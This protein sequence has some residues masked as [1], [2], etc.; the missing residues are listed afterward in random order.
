MDK[1]ELLQHVL[2]YFIFTTSFV[3]IGAIF[4]KKQYYR[5]VHISDF[6]IF[7]L[8][9]LG[10]FTYATFL[11]GLFGWINKR[12]ILVLLGI[13]VLISVIKSSKLF[14]VLFERIKDVFKEVLANPVCM[15]AITPSI[16]IIV[17]LGL[18][19]LTP[20]HVWDELAYHM[21]QVKEI[22]TSQ[23][24]SLDFGGHYFYG[25]IP[26]FMELA[27]S[28]SASVLDYSF[29]H[30]IHLS[31]FISFIIFIFDYIKRKYGIISS[32]VT[33]L[34]L[35]ISHEITSNAI[36]GYVDTATLTFEI[37]SLILVLDKGYN[38]TLNFKLFISGLLMGLAIGSK[39]SP[40]PTLLFI[41]VYIGITN[42]K[43]ENPK[44]LLKVSGVL[45]FVYGLIIF[46]SFWYFKNIV[47]YLNPFY[48]F[49]LGHKGISE[50]LYSSMIQ[51]VQQFGDRNLCNLFKILFTNYSGQDFHILPA[52]LS[53]LVVVFIIKKYKD[54]WP[55]VVYY[56]Y[57]L[58]YWFF[59]GTHQTRFLGP[60]IVVSLIVF[61]FVYSKINRYLTSTIILF[62][63]IISTRMN[64][65]WKGYIDKKL[66]L[67]ERRYSLG[68]V[69]KEGFLSQKL[70]C[71]YR[72]ISYINHNN[73]DSGIL[74]NWSVGKSP[75]LGFYMNNSTFV[76]YSDVITSDMHLTTDY[77]LDRNV[78][79]LYFNEKYR[80]KL[81][82]TTKIE[83][84]IISRSQLLFH[85]D[86]CYLYK[87][88][89]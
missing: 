78:N 76:N 68:Q 62:T 36:S 20:P 24:I 39:Y 32:S 54:I 17:A 23:K 87:I 26:K 6:A 11:L 8:L 14:S 21:P 74:D 70:G 37:I 75:P 67:E 41:F 57:Y 73:I 89:R 48:P 56:F 50:E 16:V 51:N 31:V 66:Y 1:I 5:Q 85:D 46:G 9:G 63:L 12:N 64:F 19:S 72:T 59:F 38:I 61:G 15:L 83:D 47:L 40:L 25:N 28:W 84:K 13:F 27:Y 18:S 79:Y 82:N 35:V 4:Y 86:T 33:L 3:S 71:Q 30:M 80:D 7:H 2:T 22:V 81:S 55:L 69:S 58:V 65:D 10:L 34:L 42:F 43:L 49:Y 52:L 77:L 29:A 88:Q 44:N 60:A 53:P 45:P